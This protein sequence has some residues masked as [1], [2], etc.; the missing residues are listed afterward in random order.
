MDRFKCLWF[1]DLHLA[2]VFPWTFI[3]FI[4]SINKEKPSAVFLTGDISNGPFLITHLKMM[5]K[6]IECPIYFILGNHD[7]FFSSFEEQHIKIKALCKEYPNLIWLTNSDAVRLN[8]EVALIG[9]EGWYDAEMGNPKYLT[10]TLDWILI[11]ELREIKSTKDRVEYFR[12]LAD[13]SADIIFEKLEKA[14]E[15]DYKTVYILTHMPPFKEAT[16]DEGTMLADFWLP[17]NV[18]LRLGK[19][20]EEIMATRKKRNVVVLAGHTHHPEYIRVSRNIHCQVGASKLFKINSQ[21]IFI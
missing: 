12:M 17:Y 6:F 20:I 10:A 18:N 15:Q 14:L 11:K 7:Y 2:R 9:T 5:A 8:D 13:K 16:R 19:K 4:Y 21:K 3:K 1:S